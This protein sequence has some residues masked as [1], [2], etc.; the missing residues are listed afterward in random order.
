MAMPQF[1]SLL[2][3]PCAVILFGCLGI[4]P[5]FGQPG[6]DETSA[7]SQ[8]QNIQDIL[9]NDYP[10]AAAP[11]PDAS[12]SESFLDPLVQPEEI[13]TDDPQVLHSNMLQPRP[14]LVPQAEATPQVQLP[15]S[16][17]SRLA[18]S[19]ILEGGLRRPLLAGSASS[20]RVGANSVPGSEARARST[21]DSGSLL[22]RSP[23]ILGV[24]SQR[25][26]P[27]VTDP[28]IRGSRVG[29][30]A[31]SGSYWVPARIDLD[32]MLS[33]IDSRIV[34][35]VTV[36]KGPYSSRYGPGSNFVDVQLIPTPRYDEM[37]VH[38]STS[39]DY[40]ANG[41]QWSARQSVWGGDDKSGFRISYGDKGGSA[42]Q[43]GDGTSIPAGYHSQDLDV[44]LGYDLSPSSHIE[45][46]YLRQEQGK[47]LFPGQAFDINHLVTNA[48]EMTYKQ[49]DSEFCDLLVVDAWY[50]RTQF[51]GDNLRPSKQGQFPLYP[52]LNFRAQTNVDS[53]SAGTRAASSWEHSESSVSTAGVDFREIRQDLN[54]FGTSSF[55][56]IASAGS[57]PIPPSSSSNPGLFF[58]HVERPSEC[59]ELT[60]GSRV[61]LVN[62]G[63]NG[64][65][66][67]ITN[68]GLVEVGSPHP[69][70]SSLLG[71]SHFDRN[72]TLTSFFMTAEYAVNDLWKLTGA[73]GS[74]QRA[75]NLTELYATGPFMFLLQNGLNTVTG[76]PTLKPERTWQ[77]DIGTQYATDKASFGLTGFHAWTQDFITFENVGVVGGPPFG[78]TQQVNLQFVNTNLATL[79]GFEAHAQYELTD[80]LTPFGTMNYVAGT[81][82]TRNGNFATIPGTAGAPKSRDYN[83]VRGGNSGVAGGSSEPLPQ[84][85]PL[86][87]RLGIRVHE[88]QAAPR[89]NVELAAR[90][91]D[92]Q[93]RVARS[94]L[95]QTTPGLTIWDI[96]GTWQ[97]SPRVL[98]VSGVQNF[99]NKNFQEHLDYRPQPGGG[100]F[101]ML[102]PGASFYFGTEVN[103]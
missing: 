102:Q 73:A 36:I 14:L 70:L 59:L 89:W 28:R 31:A 97:A 47:V 34:Q 99:T 81:D 45:F 77:I 41:Q 66:S 86:Q 48:F 100:T 91:V 63:L 46:N 5:L 12:E 7:E 42:Y 82:L 24:G 8:V 92:R 61:D 87:T 38:G 85:L 9:T 13:F 55:F 43:S 50:N 56:G 16:A 53:M 79:A 95:E 78:A 58:E 27:I 83:Q 51:N 52:F 37:E 101:R 17:G 75:P 29:T 57:S 19:G 49:T 88:Q 20:R 26:T 10:I 64:N 80:W 54:E 35:D 39:A 68:L 93:D 11:I 76:D 22:D 33:K 69:N 4:S 62:T 44:V 15:S 1:Q 21:T 103:Y 60:F 71:T 90:I 23:M 98:L 32:T 18:N 25:R 3:I 84:I 65:G 6:F 94:L 96:R 40:N 72:F 2:R 74:G 30:L 67:S